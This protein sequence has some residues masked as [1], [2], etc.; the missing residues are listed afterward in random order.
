MRKKSIKA[1]LIEDNPRDTRL[2]REMIKEVGDNIFGLECT[3]R[4]SKGLEC[5]NKTEI[6]VVLLDLS[7]PDCSGINTFVILHTKLP[8]VPVVVLSDINDE[9][10]AIKAMQVGAQDYLVKGELEGKLLVRSIRYAIERQKLLC[11]LQEAN[12]KVKTLQGILPICADCKK[13]RDDKGFWN[14][15]E[16]FISNHSEVDFTHSFCPECE[17]KYFPEIHKGV[18]NG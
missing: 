11:K 8:K 9:T 18:N 2:I 10:M 4:L 7:L 13:I 14:Q 1:L 15:I 3:D 16:E 5:F 6:D 17:K 12:D